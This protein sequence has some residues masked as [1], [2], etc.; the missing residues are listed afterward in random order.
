[1]LYKFLFFRPGILELHA[2]AGYK[3]GFNVHPSNENY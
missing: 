3:A 2:I 1:M